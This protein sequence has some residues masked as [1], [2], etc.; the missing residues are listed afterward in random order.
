MTD[1]TVFPA[2]GDQPTWADIPVNIFELLSKEFERK[3]TE[4]YEKSQEAESR[5]DVENLKYYDG[6]FHANVSAMNLMDAAHKPTGYRVDVAE[7]APDFV[8]WRQVAWFADEGDF[9]D[10]TIAHT[11]RAYPDK[12]LTLLP[13]DMNRADLVDMCRVEGDYRFA[14]NE[15]WIPVIRY[16]IADLSAQATR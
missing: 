7:D 1:N 16:K 8:N 5:G 11:R 15:Q 13:T 9:I 10:F 6:K 4:A 3:A 12:R 2:T 14:T